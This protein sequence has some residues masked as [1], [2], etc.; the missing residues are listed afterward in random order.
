MEHCKQR[1]QSGKK[2]SFDIDTVKAYL[3]IN[4]FDY[5]PTGGFNE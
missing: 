1:M 5:Y 3:K 2:I 4:Q